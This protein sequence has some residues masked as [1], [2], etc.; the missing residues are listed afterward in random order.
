MKKLQITASPEVYDARLLYE[1]WREK[2][3]GNLADFYRFM[4]TP[5]GERDIFVNNHGHLIY[6]KGV[7]CMQL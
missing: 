3:L 6:N 4:T 2:H 5:S 1:V 7:A